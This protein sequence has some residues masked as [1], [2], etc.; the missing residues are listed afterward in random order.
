[1]VNVFLILS[2]PL[3]GNPSGVMRS[4]QKY[5]KAKKDAGMIFLI[6]RPES[7]RDC[8]IVHCK[9]KIADK[10]EIIYSIK[11]FLINSDR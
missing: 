4:T 5:R 10:I 3:V 1:V 7:F 6:P 8:R 11:L 9:L 2:F